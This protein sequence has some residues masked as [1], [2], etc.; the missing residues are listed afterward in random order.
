VVLGMV[1]G[2]ML[3]VFLAF[4]RNFLDNQ[5]KEVEDDAKVISE[6]L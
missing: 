3:G 4:F 1:L 2:F 6:N 5:R